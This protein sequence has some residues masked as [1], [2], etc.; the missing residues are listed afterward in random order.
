[1]SHEMELDTALW[2]RSR[3]H[4]SCACCGT[5]PVA[6]IEMKLVRLLLAIV[7]WSRPGLDRNSRDTY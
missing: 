1:V 2:S 7:F 4:I 6:E 5:I 3:A